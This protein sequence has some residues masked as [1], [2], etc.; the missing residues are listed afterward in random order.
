MAD[1]PVVQIGENSPEYVAWRL[2]A[3]INGSEQKRDRAGVLDL[4]AECLLTV[5]NPGSRQKGKHET[6][7][8]QRR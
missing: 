6:Y 8:V 7:G 1:A 3:F 4:Y 5:Q 2:F